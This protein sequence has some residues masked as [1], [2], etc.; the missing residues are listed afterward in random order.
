MYSLRFQSRSVRQARDNKES[1][2]KNSNTWDPEDRGSTFFRNIAKRLP[3]YKKLYVGNSIQCVE[4]KY[5]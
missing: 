5:F 4:I 1:G 2:G 3:E